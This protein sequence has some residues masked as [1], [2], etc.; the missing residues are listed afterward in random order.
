MEYESVYGDGPLDSRE[1]LYHSDPFW[2]EANRSPGY[3]SKT[4]I[5]VAN[6][7]QTCVDMGK[8]SNNETRIATRF[9]PADFYV[10]AEHDIS[11]IISHYTAIVGRPWLK[12]RYALGHGQA[13]YGYDTQQKVEE[14]ADGY[15]KSAFPLDTMHIDIDIQEQYR[16]FTVDTSAGKFPRPR[17]MFSDLRKDGIKCSTNITPFINSEACKSYETLNEMISKEYYVPDKRYLH[18]TVTRFSD[19]RY[20]CYESGKVIISDP[21]V[22]RPGFGDNYVFEDCFNR[23]RSVPYHGGVSYGKNLGKPGYYPDLNREEVREWWGKQYRNLIQLGLEFVWQDMTSPSIAKEYGDMKS[24]VHLTFSR[25]TADKHRF[26]CRLLLSPQD[27]GQPKKPAIEIW[28]LY[29]YNLHKATF[30]GWND[31]DERKGKRNFIIGRGSFSGMHR[32]AGLWTGDNAGTWDFLSISVSQALALG[33]SGM[34][35]VGGDVGGFMPGKPGELY[36]EPELLIRWYSACFLLPWF[37]LVSTLLPL[38]LG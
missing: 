19:Q 5:F 15:K 4:G 22:D 14:T 2:I 24:C 25:N 3:R 6:Y 21:N 13:S 30:K 9:G 10:I 33:L 17:S 18:G 29:A 31:S 36:T 34:T 23:G 16:T 12:P 38:R 37:R 27:E 28:S 11:E 26:P 1:P 20:L 35:V 32:F 8:S 7:S